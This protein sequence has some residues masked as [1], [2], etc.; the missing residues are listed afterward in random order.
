MSA[1]NIVE[2]V[3]SVPIAKRLWTAN[4]DS[5]LP[6]TLQNFAIGAVLPAVLYMFRW[7]HRRG[8]GKFQKVFGSGSTKP[9]IVDITAV[10]TAAHTEFSTFDSVVKRRVLGDLLLCYLLENKGHQEGQ[11]TE[12]QRV[13]PTHYMSSWIDLPYFSANLRFVPEMLVALLA[14]QSEEQFVKPSSSPTRFGVG[15]GFSDNILLKI[16]VKVSA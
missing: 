10:L 13:F 9:R 12:V 11:N 15:A 6:V 5:L 7:G 2:S 8:Q 1:K 3:F 14:Q 4:V 16:S